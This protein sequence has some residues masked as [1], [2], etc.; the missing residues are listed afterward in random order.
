MAL[1][2]HILY[3]VLDHSWLKISWVWLFTKVH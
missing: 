1:Y 3:E 2:A